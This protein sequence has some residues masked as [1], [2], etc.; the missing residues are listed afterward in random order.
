MCANPICPLL[1]SD[2]GTGHQEEREACEEGGAAV[3]A[4]GSQES[5]N[6]GEGGDFPENL[7]CLAPFQQ[8]HPLQSHPIPYTHTH[9]LVA[10]LL[11]R[12]RELV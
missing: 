12:L 2:P 1:S 6:R 9:T 5:S 7:S 10:S 3:R 8:L 11:E 4:D